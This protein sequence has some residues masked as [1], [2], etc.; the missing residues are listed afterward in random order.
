M[1]TMRLPDIQVPRLPE[2]PTAPSLDPDSLRQSMDAM[3]ARWRAETE[4]LVMPGTEAAAPDESTS[5]VPQDEA[6]TTP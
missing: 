3:R 4:G 5:K 2:R 1:P 6:A